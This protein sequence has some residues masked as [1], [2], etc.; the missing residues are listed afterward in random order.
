MENET[1][2]G[3]GTLLAR[4]FWD[5]EEGV[6]VYN[7]VREL[8]QAQGFS[9]GRVGV[10][11]T[12]DRPARESHQCESDYE[13]YPG[14]PRE[15]AFLFNLSALDAA[16]HGRP[17]GMPRYGEYREGLRCFIA[18]SCEE[19][20]YFCRYGDMPYLSPVTLPTPDVV[21]LH[22]H[23]CVN[24]ALGACD[25]RNL[26]TDLFPRNL[27][28]AI[29]DFL[30]A[31]GRQNT[32]YVVFG[33]TN[34]NQTRNCDHSTPFQAY[35]NVKGFLASN[36]YNGRGFSYGHLTVM[37]PWAN[38][39]SPDGCYEVP[40]QLTP[41]ISSGPPTAVSVDPI[42]SKQST[43]QFRLTDPDGY[44]DLQSASVNITQ[45]VQRSDSNACWV[46]FNR[47]ANT[48]QLRNDGG[49]AWMSPAVA[50]GSSGSVSNSQ[51]TVWGAGA[52]AVGGAGELTLTIPF[53]FGASFRGTKT[54]H[55]QT[56]DG[57][58]TTTWGPRGFVGG[59][60]TVVF[61]AHN[62]SGYYAAD[63]GPLNDYNAIQQSYRFIGGPPDTNLEG[64]WP[65][66]S[67]AKNGDV[68]VA[69]ISASG[70]VWA[71]V[72]RRSTQSWD[73]W[74]AAPVR[75][76][77][78][79]PSVVAVSPGQAWVVARGTDDRVYSTTFSSAGVFGGWLDRCGDWASDPA[80]A[81]SPDGTVVRV[82]LRDKF[83]GIWTGTVNDGNCGGWIFR[84]GQTRGDLRMIATR[85]GT[86][87][88]VTRDMWDGAYMLVVP[89]AS[90][91][92]SSWHFLGGLWKDFTVAADE[93]GENIR[94]AGLDRFDGIWVGE[95]GFDGSWFGW[96]FQGGILTRFSSAQVNGRFTVFGVNSFDN[97]YRFAMESGTWDGPHGLVSGDPAASGR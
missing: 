60:P 71:N 36:L 78:G 23:V 45:G 37:R 3:L 56:V 42:E 79:K 52:Q 38:A 14:G 49:S 77:K 66:A 90:G 21:D 84:G 55:M 16:I 63:Y 35:W 44:S 39:S 68:F 89:Q 69:V 9:A 72:F 46:L 96:L 6:S 41:Y 97:A 59:D 25:D 87:N 92:P 17:F 19:G 15:S 47:P 94:I 11:V 12:V 20:N 10:S 48:L 33:E 31:R 29:W 32:Q 26:E 7:K 67:Q 73:V 1:M 40:H 81:V 5:S 43:L 28:N 18:N 76:M 51:C 2:M 30:L 70:Q 80:T 58:Y 82:A 93:S 61:K 4:L 62:N 88:L 22:T 95:G 34:T 74:R 24:N 53:T 13:Q 91:L 50:L 75:A 57:S 83:D 85:A 65:S 27:Y 86:F 8:M 54:V 64:S